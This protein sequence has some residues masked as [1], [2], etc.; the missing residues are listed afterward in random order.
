[1][2]TIENIGN[3]ANEAA[4]LAEKAKAKAEE[5]AK[6]TQEA[7][8]KAAEIKAQKEKAEK[9]VKEAKEK[10]ENLKS[11]KRKMENTIRNLQMPKGLGAIIVMFLIR[12]LK[13]TYN[14]ELAINLLK[15]EFEDKCPF[16]EKLKE[17][18]IKKNRIYNA[19][20]Q[21]QQIIQTLTTT[22]QTITTLIT[23]ITV[24][25]NILKKATIASGITPGSPPAPPIQTNNVANKTEEQVEQEKLTVEQGL[26][27]LIIINFSLTKLTTLLNQIE[28]FISL[29]LI[30]NLESGAISEDEYNSILIELNTS[31][32]DSSNEEANKL[33]GENILNQGYKGFRFEVQQNKNNPLETIPQRRVVGIQIE[34]DILTVA[35]DYSFSST[36]EVLV[37]EAKF[38][39]DKW[40]IEQ[41][42][43]TSNIDLATI[44]ILE[45]EPIIPEIP[46]TPEVDTSAADEAAA[47]M[48]A[49][50]AE[51]ER[52]AEIASLQGQITGW[53]SEINSIK[54][55]LTNAIDRV[56]FNK[57]NKKDFKDKVNSWLP[58]QWLGK[59][60]INAYKR[61]ERKYGD[62]TGD[63]NAWFGL[64]K[65]IKQNE[66][67]IA[68][69]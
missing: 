68:K 40:Y 42:P 64:N 66:D 45:D 31:S 34:T 41:E 53:E 9:N 27:G 25:I 1:M 13:S 24:I 14:A 37:N 21:I 35:T 44:K 62:L 17:I 33:K 54:L 22:T 3:A 29:C 19:V 11:R 69:L 32:T 63:L 56:N 67:K 20:T 49:A 12:T 65:K 43:V 39:I 55:Q 30:E 26:S 47:Q 23:S 8:E 5:L 58:Q 50:Q 16:P 28:A 60:G 52:K 61:I 48:S 59:K 38:L 51:A 7:K 15:K 46:E 2:A 36:T 4:I 18:I 10:V 6:I 57:K